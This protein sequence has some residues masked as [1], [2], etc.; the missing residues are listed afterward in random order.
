MQRKKITFEKVGTSWMS[1]NARTYKIKLEISTD[2]INWESIF[3]GQTSGTTNEVEYVNAGNKNARFVRCTAY[4]NSVN[5][6]NSLTEFVVL[7]NQR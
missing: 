5:N 4:G 6:W 2:G 1:G 3:E 7:G